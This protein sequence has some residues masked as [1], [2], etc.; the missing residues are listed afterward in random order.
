MKSLMVFLI[1]IFL[2]VPALFGE[3]ENLLTASVVPYAAIPAGS[4]TDLFKTGFGANIS[5]SFYP[6]A[7]K[8]IGF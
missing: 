4:S 7:L 2:I 3:T 1:L 8:S 5:A 6:A